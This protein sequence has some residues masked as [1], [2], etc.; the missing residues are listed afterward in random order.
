MILSHRPVGSRTY[1][2][3]ACLVAAVFVCWQQAQAIHPGL[4]R[5][6]VNRNCCIALYLDVATRCRMAG[7]CISSNPRQAKAAAPGQFAM[8]IAQQLAPDNG[9]SQI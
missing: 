8:A 2:S 5:V 1:K 3:V 4:D 7:I 6:A 9:V